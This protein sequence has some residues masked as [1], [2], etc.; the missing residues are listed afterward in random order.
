MTQVYRNQLYSMTA[1]EVEKY[2]QVLRDGDW[3][4]EDCI[5]DWESESMYF[6]DYD[7]ARKKFNRTRVTPNHPIIRLFETRYDEYG[8]AEDTALLDEKY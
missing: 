1:Y 6:T 3:E 2:R 4:S 8:N 5:W 7:E